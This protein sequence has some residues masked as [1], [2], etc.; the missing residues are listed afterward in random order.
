MVWKD[1]SKLDCFLNYKIK[2]HILYLNDGNFP[3]PLEQ[4]PGKIFVSSFLYGNY[5]VYFD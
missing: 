3:P 5:F 1:M 2:V 4:Y